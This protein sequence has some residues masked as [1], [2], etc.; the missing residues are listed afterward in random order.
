MTSVADGEA[1][2]AALRAA[3]PPD[4]LILDVMLPGRNG[5]EV[6]KAVEADA[7]L[8]ALPVIGADRQDPGRTTAQLAEELGADAY[9]TKP[10]SNADIVEQ[11]RR[12]DDGAG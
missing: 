4:L 2:L 1:A 7:R 11:V 3:E 6:L 12:L 5:F 10:F 9:V 8:R